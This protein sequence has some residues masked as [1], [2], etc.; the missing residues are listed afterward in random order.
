MLDDP[1]FDDHKIDLDDVAAAKALFIDQVTTK[2]TVQSSSIGNIGNE[3]S[4]DSLGIASIQASLPAGVDYVYKIKN[5]SDG[6]L[7]ISTI[8]TKG[9]VLDT[10][11]FNII[12]YQTQ[13]VTDVKDV[14]AAKALFTDKNTT[15]KTLA[16]TVG[17]A[18]DVVSADDLGITDPS[19]PTGV[20]VSYA[21]KT[22]N[23]VS[24]VVTATITKG[25]AS[26]T[27]DFTV[28]NYATQD[29]IDVVAARA[30]FT[31]KETTKTTTLASAVGTAGQHI[32]S[33]DIGI[34]A[35]IN[36]LPAGVSYNY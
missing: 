24:L 10:I 16:S 25:T 32:G 2:T 9:D 7:V 19:L 11:D 1:S 8:I 27:I 4:S 29:A 3:V 28:K 14:Q 13:D 20:L 15:K 17:V 6:S 36:I 31:D 18:G 22:V 30:F 26:D 21:I 5:I 12:G 23:D 35:V 33:A 34:P